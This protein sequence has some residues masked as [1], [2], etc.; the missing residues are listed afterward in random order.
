MACGGINKQ[1]VIY[2]HGVR[3]TGH[4]KI[5]NTHL[6]QILSTPS[7]LELEPLE[8]RR[9]LLALPQYPIHVSFCEL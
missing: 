1:L 7:H 8:Q 6:T 4:Q 5:G 9:L 3:T 2:G